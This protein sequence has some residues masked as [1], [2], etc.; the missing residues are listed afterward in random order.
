MQTKQKSRLFKITHSRN[1]IPK[2]LKLA[3]LK[4]LN[5]LYGFKLLPFYGN[6]KM[7]VGAILLYRINFYFLSFFCSAFFYFNQ[8][9]ICF[10][11]ICLDAN[12][13]KIKTHQIFLKFHSKLYKFINSLRS[14]KIN[15]LH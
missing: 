14:D 3:S 10:I 15:L 11:F 8:N 5:F 7:S 13:A 4:Q 6:F 9:S 1:L 2:S 12:E